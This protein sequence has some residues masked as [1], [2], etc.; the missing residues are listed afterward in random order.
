MKLIEDLGMLYPTET[1]SRKYRYGLYEC[2][3]CLKPF[4]AQSAD[5]KL[6][7]RKYCSSCSGRVSAIT[8]GLSCHKLYSIWASQKARCNSKSN[9]AYVSYGARGIS[10]SEEFMDF[11]I[12]LKY[13]ESL[14]DC[15]RDG[16]SI[17][18]IDNDKGYERGNLRWANR[19]TQALNTRKRKGSSVYRG[20]C[21][22][23]RDKKWQATIANNNKT[24]FLGSFDTP[25]EGAYAYDR[26]I[27]ENNLENTRN[28]TP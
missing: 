26:Y 24:I 15:C 10:V 20:V 11:P 25:R 28:F 2:S 1:S 22:H 18:R 14:D 27:I 9:K 6:S 16:Y 3:K 13:I 7:N 4:K 23:T 12:W 19:R 8:H 5:V 17:D 21:W